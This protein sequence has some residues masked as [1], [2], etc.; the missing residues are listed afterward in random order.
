MLKENIENRIINLLG[1]YEFR[2][3]KLSNFLGC[4]SKNDKLY[5]ENV[6]QK[7]QLQGLIYYNEG[8]YQLF[9]KKFVIT[10]IEEMNHKKEGHT[11]CF[12]NAKNVLVPIK[13]QDLNGAML[14]DVV[15]LDKKNRIVKRILKRK[16][17]QIHCEVVL[18]DGV[19]QLKALRFLGSSYLKVRISHRDM[20]KLIPGSIILV[21]LTLDKYDSYYEGNMVDFVGHKDDPDIA[22][23]IIASNHGFFL[24]HSKEA[25]DE[26]YKM[27]TKVEEEDRVGRVDLRDEQIFTI[28]GI[29]TKDM[30]D[31]VGLKELSNGNYELTVSIADV[32]YYVKPGSHLWQEAAER[33]TSLY[34]VNSVVPMFPHLLS[35]GICSLNEGKDRLALTCFIIL[36]K[37][38]KVLEYKVLPTVINSKKKM[39]YRDVEQIINGKMVEGYEPFAKTLQKM[40]E[41]SLILKRKRNAILFDSKDISYTFDENKNI[42]D[43]DKQKNNEAMNIIEEFMI[44]ANVC[45]A[46]YS[47]YLA[48]ATPYRIHEAPDEYKIDKLFEQ[49]KLGKYDIQDSITQNLYDTLNNILRKYQNSLDYPYISNLIL[50]SMKRAKYSSYNEGH[51]A[52]K[53]G[54]Y[55]HFTSPIRRFPD[56]LLHYQIHTVLD[57]TYPDKT[58]D[59]TKMEELCYHASFMEQAADLAEKEADEYTILRYMKNHP[60]KIYRGYIV[61]LENDYVD[62]VISSGIKGRISYQNLS[63]EL[64]INQEKGVIY[65]HKNIYLKLGNVCLFKAKD[66]DLS[67]NEVELELEKNL[68]IR[69]YEK[70][71]SRILKK[72]H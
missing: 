31:A 70:D 61:G 60:E 57:K 20:K 28:D 14:G 39:S 16:I 11:A 29:Y 59:D 4:K 46:K 13:E 15:V 25:L 23:N 24:N 52:L 32:N 18:E 67:R 72:A 50:K 10:T 65:F 44:L 64:T 54:Y 51:Y 36:N 2:F 62:I 26:A 27:P 53:E 22:L 69:E 45:M 56:L 66:I 71:F 68:S 42:I 3:K 17:K 37:E 48:M 63:N 41:L 9:P 6:L 43:I 1:K 7:M 19:K 12:Q 21:E 55:A 49:L 8:I 58:I 47:T 38:G 34:M 33:S 35:N 30:D 5:L 40:Y